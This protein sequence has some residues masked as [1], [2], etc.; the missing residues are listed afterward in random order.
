[1][2]CTHMQQFVAETDAE[3]STVAFTE[4]WQILMY[5][6]SWFDNSVKHIDEV[7]FYSVE[8]NKC[9]LMLHESVK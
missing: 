8:L 5:I 4:L 1:M 9:L 6:S 3:Q 7:K 2:P